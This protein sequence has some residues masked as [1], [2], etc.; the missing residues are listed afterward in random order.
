MNLPL[1]LMLSS[2]CAR[3]LIM[4][5]PLPVFDIDPALDPSPF[6]GAG[7]ALGCALDGVALLCAMALIGRAHRCGGRAA[8][9]VA[10][11]V[12]VLALPL[13]AVGAWWGM[14]DGEQLWRAS[15]WLSGVVCVGALLAMASSDARSA[16][17]A[18][19]AAVAAVCGTL[20]VLAVRGAS[21]VLSEHPATVAHYDAHRDA[22]LAAQGWTEGSPQ[23]RAYERRLR[24]R[25]ASGWFGFSNVYATVA[26]SGAV[27]LMGVA[28]VRSGQ[29]RTLV[30]GAV[31][32]GLAALVAVSGSKG[33][34]A[35]MAV[36]CGVAAMAM[37]IPAS[38]GR[39]GWMRAALV[40][41]PLA[42]LALPWV[43]WVAGG[44][45]WGERSLLVRA[46]YLQ[47]AWDAVRHSPWVGWGPGG[48]QLADLSFRPS[49]SIEEV[50]SAHAAIADWCAGLGA[51]A[52][53][54]LAGA[55]ALIAWRVPLALAPARSTAPAS[56]QG[57]DAR[58]A[59][60]NASAAIAVA[61]LLGVGCELMALDAVSA[62]VRVAALAGAVWVARMA[63]HAVVQACVAHDDR[64]AAASGTG[65]GAC[66][67]GAAAALLAHGQIDM[68]FWLPGSAPVAW[69]ALGACAAIGCARTASDEP[70]LER[71]VGDHTPEIPPLS[72]GMRTL[73]AS[74]V[75]AGLALL[76]AGGALAR[77][78]LMMVRAAE[79]VS[80]AGGD[81][82]SR[83]RAARS[84]LQ[85]WTIDPARSPVAVAAAQ[86][87]MAAVRALPAGASGDD[88][89]AVRAT[90][91]DA[92]EAA[93]AASA[94]SASA[95]SA[96]QAR[97][98]LALIAA[99][100]KWIGWSAALSD[101]EE[102]VAIDPR[103]VGAW[104]T[105]AEA[106]E[107][108]GDRR[109]AADAI[110]RALDADASYALDPV[111]QM[112]DARRRAWA[113]KSESLHRE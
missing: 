5:I 19:A 83:V 21:Q 28:L 35:A 103:S 36:G 56:Q 101:C 77:Q 111:R 42:A 47:S 14:S 67:V 27:L 109:G 75:A 96:A 59:W 91:H 43:R 93:G 80:E 54:A 37:A 81:A 71:T 82:P 90:V 72:I 18:A 98:R 89:E 22:V 44:L 29:R 69:L 6:A 45:E 12:I 57:E 66:A 86:Q 84:L 70:A 106:R 3:A 2:L 104:L 15:A 11:P 58:T 33:G 78:D 107:G 61:W 102:A 74:V 97:A 46:G 25:E 95:F 53:V 10:A 8:L 16:R 9:R 68:A 110:G 64:P 20:T 17:M 23:A 113:A 48:F 51:P 40:M 41:A 49:W 39:V 24:Q 32:A 73:R 4:W 13:A 55:L 76:V 7:P 85:A 94:L 87:A 30:C 63:A 26:A 65:L 99:Q 50:S 112:G 38:R 108:A 88:L 100:R 62:L 52:G 31:A 60:M 34:I 92:H 1:A 79:D 105:L